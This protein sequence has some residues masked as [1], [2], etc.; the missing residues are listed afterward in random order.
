MYY[1]IFEST[2]FSCFSFDT[3]IDSAPLIF[4]DQFIQISSQLS[5]HLLYGIGGRKSTLLHNASSWQQFAMWARD[6]AP[7]VI[8]N[9]NFNFLKN[10]F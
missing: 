1:Q 4:A 8:F 7:Q 9:L 3:M 10:L 2:I 5:T 6:Q